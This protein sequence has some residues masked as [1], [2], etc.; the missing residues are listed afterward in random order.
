MAKVSTL[1][2][3]DCCYTPNSMLNSDAL[4]SGAPVSFVRWA[5]A[6]PSTAQK[7]SQYD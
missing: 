6:R 3:D 1:D 4:N 2:N 7:D 5:D